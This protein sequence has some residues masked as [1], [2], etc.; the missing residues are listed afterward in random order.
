[1][2]NFKSLD[3]QVRVD[4]GV[5]FA[6]PY[7]LE[8]SYFIYPPTPDDDEDLFELV[9]IDNDGHY[10]DDKSTVHTTLQDAQK[11]AQNHYVNILK[12]HKL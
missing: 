1:M 6:E 4:D 7:G 12:H 9:L 8:H 3:W 2:E 11:H 5:V 10:D